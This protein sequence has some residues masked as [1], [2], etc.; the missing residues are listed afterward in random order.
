MRELGRAGTVGPGGSLP[1]GPSSSQRPGGLSS[2]GA[3]T[4]DTEETFIAADSTRRGGGGGGD[5]GELELLAG[6]GAEVGGER[7]W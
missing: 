3:M 7:R 5:R 6:L 2:S 4:T 1:K